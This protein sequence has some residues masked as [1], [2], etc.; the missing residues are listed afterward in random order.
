MAIELGPWWSLDYL[1]YHQSLLR[2]EEGCAE[3]SS[4]SDRP[5]RG[6]VLKA[7][8][9]VSLP[10]GDLAVSIRFYT[11]VLLL[12]L[13][14]EIPGRWASFEVGGVEVALYPRE[15]DEGSGGDLAFLVEDLAATME[16]L[17]ASGVEFPHG[18]E[19]FD[20]PTG[21]GRLARFHDPSGNRLELIERSRSASE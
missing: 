15:S 20:L 19:A 7:I 13:Q 4:L 5:L 1:R 17:K 9:Y 3:T 10:V 2:R 14:F 8:D 16:R 21:T 18:I 11:D 12:P 6:P